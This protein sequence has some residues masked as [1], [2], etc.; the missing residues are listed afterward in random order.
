[1][2]VVTCH[3]CGYHYPDNSPWG[4]C[5]HC[6]STVRR[7]EDEAWARAPEPD[8]PAPDPSAVT[9]VLDKPS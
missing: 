1:M 9:P 8:V 6:G 5:P 3:E 7:V 2:R 4:P